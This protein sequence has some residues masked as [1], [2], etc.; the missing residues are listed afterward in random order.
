[1]ALATIAVSALLPFGCQSNNE[2]N[3]GGETSKVA[4]P[5]PGVPELKSYSDAMKYQM[6]EAAKKKQSKGKA[7]V[8][9]Q[10]APAAQ[11]SQPEAEKEPP[12]SP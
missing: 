7:A 2:E 6:Q 12:K 1:M 10:P 11:P 9:S 5:Q 4:P 8:K 3:L